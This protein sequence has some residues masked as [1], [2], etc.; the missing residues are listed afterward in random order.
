MTRIK[1]IILLLLFPIILFG[2]NDSESKRKFEEIDSYVKQIDSTYKDSKEGIIEGTIEYTKPKRKNGGW[3]AY[4]INDSQSKNLPLRIR[5]G[6][7][8]YDRN[9]ELDLYYK[10]GKL[11][12]AYLTVTYIVGKRPSKID[13]TRKFYFPEEKLQWQTRTP[14]K[15]FQDA[16][17]EYSFEY[18]FK[19]ES[20]IRKWIYK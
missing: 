4:Y 1:K 7:A 18:L 2:Q 10:S 14:I 16:D 13:Y 9:T 6:K 12:F 8:E 3:E 5:Y 20:E 15:E 19:E 11:V 17:R